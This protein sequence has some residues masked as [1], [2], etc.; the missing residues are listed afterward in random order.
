MTKQF[1]LTI[2][3]SFSFSSVLPGADWRPISAAELAQSSPKVEKDADAEAFLWEVH[4]LDEAQSGEYPHSVFTHYIRLKIFTDR[5]KE[6]FGT[7]D[8]PYFG[9]THVTD[10][11]GRTIKADGTTVDMKKDALFDRTLVRASG[12]KVRA[13]SF[14]MPAVEPG[15]IIEYKWKESHEDTLA[16]TYVFISS[17]TFRF[18]W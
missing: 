18:R 2:A 3:L 9:R 7:V 17:A 13:K 11:A 1:F 15:V 8:I 16:T 5:G 4:V 6:K 14:A 12:L 10:V